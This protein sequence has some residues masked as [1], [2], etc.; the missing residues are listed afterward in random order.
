MIFNIAMLQRSV[1]GNYQ[2]T[3]AIIVVVNDLDGEN[4]R[5]RSI[6]FSIIDPARDRT[7]VFQ[8]EENLLSGRCL[9]T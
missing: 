8:P 1:L 2:V 9:Q 5:S 6:H 7:V 4:N 3:N